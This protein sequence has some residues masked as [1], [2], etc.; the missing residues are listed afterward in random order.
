M[1]TAIGISFILVFLISCSKEKL[2]IESP[3]LVGVWQ[4]YSAMDA[5]EILIINTDG[6][7]KVEWYTNNKLHEE[8]KIKDWYVKENR[9]YFGKVTFALNPYD[10]TGYPQLSSQE[11]IIE[12]DTLK[13]LTRYIELN[14]LNYVEIN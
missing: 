10:V 3:S 8:T 7:G 5:W 13:P 9:L 12:F 11:E 1:K 2:I 4:H 14:Q 6:T